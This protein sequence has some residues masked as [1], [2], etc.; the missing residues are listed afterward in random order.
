MKT[1][2]KLIL[3]SLVVLILAAAC[4]SNKKEPVVVEPPRNPLLLAQDASSNGMKAFTDKSYTEAITNFSEAIN[5]YNEAVVTAAPTDSI[6]QNI[7]K[8]NLNIATSHLRMA[9]ESLE[10]QILTKPLLI[11]TQL[12]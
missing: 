2:V 1:N 9:E 4:S 12:L 10:D 8:M 5:L 6:P 3:V 11:M 7:E